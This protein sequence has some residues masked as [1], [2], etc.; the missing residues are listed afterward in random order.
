[1][2]TFFKKFLVFTFITIL[3][4]I[5]G[6][7]GISILK[8]DQLI[9][10]F[11]Q[12]IIEKSS[13]KVEF[14]KI[15]LSVFKNFP[16]LSIVLNDATFYYPGKTTTDTLIHSK[17]LSFGIDVISAFKGFYDLS[18]IKIDEGII[19]YNYHKLNQLLELQ[20][21]TKKS[22]HL[23]SARKVSVRNSLFKYTYDKN[24]TVKILINR[25]SMNGILDNSAFRFSL[26]IDFSNV[27]VKYNNYS[28]TNSHSIQLT[29]NILGN[30]NGFFT[31]P[32]SLEINSLPFNFALNYTYKNERLHIDFS[33]KQNNLKK[34]IV[35]VAGV[36]LRE[37][38]KGEGSIKGK[39]VCNLNN[40]DNQVFS[41]GFQV[42]KTLIKLKEENL[43]IKHL[44]GN[45]LI[46]GR[47]ER[48]TTDIKELFVTY[49][50][51]DL[52]GN[53]KMKNIPNPS[54]LL[55]V[56][57]NSPNIS[58][59]NSDQFLSGTTSGNVK[60]LIQ[61]KN[62]NNFNINNLS[63]L[64][65]YTNISFS[66]ISIKSFD[67]IEN[68]SGNL[69]I[70]DNKLEILGNGILYNSSFNAS[71]MVSN[72]LD[73][74]QYRKPF[75][76]TI[77]ISIDSLNFNRFTQNTKGTKLNI[78]DFKM[79]GQIN[80]L[81]YKGNSINDFLFKINSNDKIL[82]VDTFSMNAFSGKISGS[83]P[84]LDSSMARMSISFRNI[85][86]NSAF[87]SFDNFGQNSITHKNIYG[88][89]SGLANISFKFDPFYKIET[90]SINLNS[91]IILEN[92]VLVETDL[93]K[94]IS[95]L[96]KLKE[97]ESIKFK[98]LN[99]D[100]T[101]KEGKLFIPTMNISS[102]ALNIQ[103]SGEHG[104]TG[105]YTYW[106]KINLKEVLARRFSSSNEKEPYFETDKQGGLNIFL[107]IMGDSSSYRISY[108]KKNAL[109]EIKVNINSEGSLL[110]SLINDEFG[111]NKK[112]TSFNSL[113]L[114]LNKTDSTNNKV[115]KNAFKIEWDEIDT[116]RI[117][118]Q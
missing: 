25:A 52:I 34:M 111:R 20:K 105:D 110:K 19:N 68:L 21:N 35:S 88:S 70:N 27:L 45:F 31:Q 72:F 77:N 39:Y 93:F 86:I 107:K 94:N 4:G 95:V 108:D 81:Y 80:K 9:S 62:I 6:L 3:L 32:S 118:N 54:I 17:H 5:V 23:I 109:K 13:V 8:K 104:F 92:G 100:I 78:P 55:D 65:L 36:D 61:V 91:K 42:D 85:D 98:T 66:D 60:S 57:V 28:Y 82:N 89:L 63:I 11:K 97:L 7:I 29:S 87:K 12:E 15:K 74:F 59:F 41:I 40:I 30:E 96:L 99:N 64:K 116:T 79:I 73:V 10:Q 46:N 58:L 33:S 16:N 84:L 2:F 14:S 69:F 71:L 37:I 115:K 113:K 18:S 51:V 112:D 101:I 48:N 43:Y 24:L 47:F 83:V 26:M 22:S 90:K 49:K 76:P 44:A 53:A 114:M 103:L 38:E 1:M 50:G 67:S 56:K 102:N 75:T 106:V 117:N